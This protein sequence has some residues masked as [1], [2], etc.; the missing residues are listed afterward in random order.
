MELN[1]SKYDRPVKQALIMV[2]NGNV[3]TVALDL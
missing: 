1:A 2:G 3:Q